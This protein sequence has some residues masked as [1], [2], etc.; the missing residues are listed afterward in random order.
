MLLLRHDL[1]LP[2]TPPMRGPCIPP[3]IRRRRFSGGLSVVPVMAD[4]R[5]CCASPEDAG[6]GTGVVEGTGGAVGFAR[7]A[8]RPSVQDQP[9]RQIGPLLGRKHA[10][11]SR[12]ICRV[13]MYAAPI[14][15]PAQAAGHAITCV[16]TGSPARRTRCRAPHSRFPPDTGHDVSSSMCADGV[17]EPFVHVMRHRDDIAGLAW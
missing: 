14:G 8:C 7:M 11:I 9:V 4:R 6:A 16:S 13:R 5:W 2:R 15:T 17:T 10:V 12:S 1:S 3:S